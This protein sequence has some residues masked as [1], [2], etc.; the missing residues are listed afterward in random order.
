MKVIL[1]QDVEALG[2]AGQVVEVA[3]GYARN[4]LIPRQQALIAT[5][6]SAAQFASRQKQLAA[7]SDR[8]R[9]AAEVLAKQLGQESLT[10]AAHVGEEDRLFGSITAQ[11]V[12]DLLKEKGYEVD[13]R[14]IQLEE[15]IRKLGDYSVELRLHPQVTATVRLAVVRG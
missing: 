12:A 2:Q 4:Y 13:R 10:A 3:P 11:H 14:V 1:L 5:D 9:R 15:P 7:V 8:E 6:R